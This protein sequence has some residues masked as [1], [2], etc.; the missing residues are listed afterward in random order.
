MKMIHEWHT[1]NFFIPNKC[2]IRPVTA[3]LFLTENTDLMI[4]TIVKMNSFPRQSGYK[5]VLYKYP[6][7]IT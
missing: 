4:H 6:V 5:R 7:I 2:D 1:Y 3:G